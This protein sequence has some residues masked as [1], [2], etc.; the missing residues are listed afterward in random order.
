MPEHLNS[1]SAL[2]RRP[3]SRRVVLASS[4]GLL[5]AA[6]L[7]SSERTLPRALVA[8]SATPTSS[9]HLVRPQDMLVLDFDFYNLAPAF[10]TDPPQLRRVDS[11]VL[12]YVVARFASQHVMEQ[13]VF[14]DEKNPPAPGK[15]SG[16]AVGPSRIVF[17]VPETVK[18]LP[19]NEDGLLQWWPWIMQAVT[20]PPN[21]SP[22]DDLH[23]DLL[24]VDWLHLTPERESTWA[25][26]TR[27]VTH[28]DRTELWHTRLAVRG[29]NGR[30]QESI[31]VPAPADAAIPKLRA[32]YY[33]APAGDEATV[34]SALYPPHFVDPPKQIVQLAGNPTLGA[35]RPVNADLLSLSAAGATLDFEA[36]WIPTVG[37]E[38]KRWEHHSWLGRDNKVVVEEYGFLFPFGHRAEL[39]SETK[40]QIDESGVAY[41]RQRLFIRITERVKTYAAPFQNWAG[42]AFPFTD[43]TIRNTTLPDLPR[44]LDPLLPGP[45]NATAPAFWIQDI[46]APKA[47]GGHSDVVFSLVATDLT[48]R[49]IEFT[50]PMAF[51]PADPARNTG[52]PLFTSVLGHY[53]SYDDIV[54]PAVNPRRVIDLRGQEIAYAKEPKPGV[55]SFPTVRWYWGVEGP[56]GDVRPPL[57]PGA[58]QDGRDHAHVDS[59]L[60]YPRM[61]AAEAQVPA[62]DAV[63]GTGDPV[64]LVHDPTY[65]AHGFGHL[66]KLADSGNDPQI[67]VRVQTSVAAINTVVIKGDRTAD[68]P[69]RRIVQNTMKAGGIA[70]PN[71]AIGAISAS[72]LGPISGLQDSVDKVQNSGKVDFK[73]YFSNLGDTLQQAALFGQIALGALFEDGEVSLHGPRIMKYTDF[74]K[75]K[76]GNPDYDAKP[77]GQTVTLEFRENVTPS[78]PLPLVISK[79]VSGNVLTQ[80]ILQCSNQINWVTKDEDT[81]NKAIAKIYGCLT[82]FTLDLNPILLIFTK[83]AFTYQLGKGPDCDPDLDS[84]QFKPPLDFVGALA[85]LFRG[86]GDSAVAK[87]R[88]KK[89]RSQ[90]LA[91]AADG[92]KAGFGFKLLKFDLT[93]IGV[94]V[95]FDIPSLPLGFFALDG[96]HIEAGVIL[97]FNPA[98]FNLYADLPRARFAFG[99]PD[100]KFKVSVYGLGGGGHFEIEVSPR[101]IE[102]LEASIEVLGNVALDVLVAA[103]RVLIELGVFFRLEI[104]D[105]TDR[106]GTY[107]EV[108]LGGYVRVTG[109][110]S[111]LGLI[112]INAEL[113]ADIE[114]VNQ[115]GVGSVW[116][117]AH[118]TVSI[119]ITFWHVSVGIEFTKTFGGA[120]QA[121]VPGGAVRALDAASA[122]PTFGD[123]VSRDDWRTYCASFAS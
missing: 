98:P 59:P 16:R 56:A 48:G 67:F 40:R 6:G 33:D 87:A 32:V 31:P 78:P 21:G 122:P 101:R 68:S 49:R 39:I 77:I 86:G 97:P 37:F 22:P 115:D 91:P 121:N 110:L 66:A 74:P 95:T 108:H 27:P 81:L 79:D 54:G 15:A 57:P 75:D 30:P 84:V 70:S 36:Q 103:G 85:D 113:Y 45:P 71:L 93:H 60:F 76:D 72:S 4:S 8:G 52:D 23:T 55:A 5:M 88:T 90:A 41:L 116:F 25:H 107:T 50:T 28:G 94:G 1:E 43:I 109:R 12:A 17:V 14:E 44:E 2:W 83:F 58:P 114:Y 92:K 7:R 34:F 65:L 64:F 117:H 51:M 19:Y 18:S 63:I 105:Y 80:F 102:K 29:T 20:G 89:R 111:V 100:D 73:A 69:V 13:T 106:P 82:D 123:L 38:L 47:G 112:S 24:V 119:D 42:R 10:D 120:S 61:F 96:L 9:L 99:A 46:N 53:G 11:S 118:L 26:A 104:K 62:I 3:I 35:Y